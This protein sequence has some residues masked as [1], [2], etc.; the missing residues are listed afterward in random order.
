[1]NTIQKILNFE[2]INY[3]SNL[4][5]D[6]FKQKLSELFS[7]KNPISGKIINEN[8][9]TAYSK[10][11]I[12]GWHMPYL[13]RKTAYLKGEILSKEKGTLIKLQIKPNSILPIFS[14]LATLT[15]IVMTTLVLTNRVNHKYFSIMSLTFLAFGI[16]YYPLSIFFRN[17][18]RNKIVK[19]LDLIKV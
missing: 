8:Q 16:L 3:T 14:I 9:F 17:Q 6:H 4:N 7:K 18:L 2:E 15:G 13:R 10:W 12:I 11:N 19:K 5:K 1:M